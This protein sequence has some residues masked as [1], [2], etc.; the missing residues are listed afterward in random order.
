MSVKDASPNGHDTHM[1]LRTPSGANGSV[2]P[3]NLRSLADNLHINLRPHHVLLPTLRI[4]QAFPAY[5]LK[6]VL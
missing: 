5:V 6:C 1:Y 4:P 2:L 3:H